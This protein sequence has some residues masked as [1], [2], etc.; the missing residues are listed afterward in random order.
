MSEKDKI[1]V[2]RLRCRHDGTEL[3]M[4][5]DT[6][7]CQKCGLNWF[8]VLFERM[9][10]IPETIQSRLTELTAANS[11]LRERIGKA[12]SIIKK[13]CGNVAI[14]E[15]SWNAVILPEIEAYEGVYFLGD[16]ITVEIKSALTDGGSDGTIK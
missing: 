14:G 10:P 15:P 1:K 12:E 8:E 6:G 13:F 2:S 9:L 4:L 7:S 3:L 5:D 16:E 11:D